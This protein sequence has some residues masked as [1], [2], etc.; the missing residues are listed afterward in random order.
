MSKFTSVDA[1]RESLP[2]ETLAI[3]DRLRSAAAASA[4]HVVEHIKW[5]APSFCKD[6]VDRI[7]LGNSPK[8]VVRVVLHRG[9]KARAND[10]FAFEAP[11][12]LVRW[13]DRDRGVME[14]DHAETLDRWD[15]N[16]K[17]V[18]RRWMELA[19]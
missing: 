4:N 13:P 8:G 5:N 9:A 17:D 7:T 12:E 6:G 11:P 10:G 18:F 2:P 3:V 14:F 15:S 16:I 1:Y 19:V